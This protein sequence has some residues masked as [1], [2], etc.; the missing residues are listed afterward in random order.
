MLSGKLSLVTGST[1][2][3]GLGV[4]RQLA[5]AGSNIIF[6]GF[7]DMTEINNLCKSFADTYK[8]KV[9]Y[10]GADL[11]DVKQIDTMMDRSAKLH[12]GIDVL[13]NNAGIQVTK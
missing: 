5:K 1:S 10:E 12:G 2:G 6:N 13:V 8:I 7:G 9:F 11:S 4:A 3:I